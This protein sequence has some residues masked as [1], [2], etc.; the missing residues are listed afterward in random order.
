MNTAPPRISLIDLEHAALSLTT[1]LTTLSLAP[2]EHQFAT[3]LQHTLHLASTASPLAAYTSFVTLYNAPSRWTHAE[4]ASFVDTHN[5]G[6]Q[7]L[8][9]HFI[10][11]QAVLTPIL[12]LERVGFQG[13]DAPTEV[14][15]WIEGIYWGVRP[16]LRGLLE[17]PVRVARYPVGRFVGEL[18]PEMEVLDFGMDMG[19]GSM[20]ESE[21]MLGE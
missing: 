14:L 8:L 9:A 12:A 6:A 17:W 11:A 19:M 4:F 16:E 13:V 21:L 2:H 7:V 10:A 1:L 18:E 15:G 5:G 20:M 3:T